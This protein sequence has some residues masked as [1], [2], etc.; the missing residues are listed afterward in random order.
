MNKRQKAKY[1]KRLYE[2]QLKLKNKH[3]EVKTSKIPII[4][5]RITKAMPDEFQANA[6]PYWIR[7]EMSEDIKK[8][9]YDNLKIN[10]VEDENNTFWPNVMFEA[11][12]RIAWE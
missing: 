7:E 5:Y 6:A 9:I 2:Q 8:I 4:T 1:Y 12:I 10:K 3:I 11:T